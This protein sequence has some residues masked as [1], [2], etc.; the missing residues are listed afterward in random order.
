MSRFGGCETIRTEDIRKL[1]EKLLNLR[2]G[3]EKGRAAKSRLRRRRGVH[4]DVLRTLRVNYLPS[5]DVDEKVK[6]LQK[7]RS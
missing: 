4:D 5:F 1:R 6:M 7:I 3:G 2:W